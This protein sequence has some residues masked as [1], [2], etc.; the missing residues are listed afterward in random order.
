VESLPTFSVHRPKYL[1]DLRGV[2][3]TSIGGTFELLFA[4]AAVV[5]EAPSNATQQAPAKYPLNG[6][7][8]YMI[9]LR[10][11]YSVYSPL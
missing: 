10:T 11:P 8:T 9:V 2:R 5:A 6:D 7:G 3:T 4:D 1:R